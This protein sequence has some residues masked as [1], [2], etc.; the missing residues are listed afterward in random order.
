[1]FENLKINLTARKAYTAHVSGNQLIDKGQVAEAKAKHEEALK[2]Y[3]EAYKGGVRDSKI[4][5]AY[6][7]LLMRFDRPEEARDLLRLCENDRSLDAASRKQM[8]V[9]YAV[10]QWKLGELDKAI[11]NMEIAASNGKTSMMYITL[12][13]F[14]VEKG[15]ETGDFSKAEEFNKEALEYDEEDAGILDNIGQMHYFK[16]DHDTAYEWFAKAYR[17]KSTQVATCYYIASINLERGN[18]EKA[19]GFIDKCLEGNFSALATIKRED[20]YA[21][22]AEIEKAMMG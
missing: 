15:R 16:G 13:Y 2:L 17:Q 12:G 6:A 20:A 10:C 3:E 8:R 21:L 14:Y 7:V 18:L 4:L 5:M 22:K 1:M 11:E 9:N 19:K